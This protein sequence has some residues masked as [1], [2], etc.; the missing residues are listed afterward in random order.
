M[1]I[2]NFFLT[3]YCPLLHQWGLNCFIILLL[4]YTIKNFNRSK[5]LAGTV[6]IYVYMN[7]DWK[8]A[9]MLAIYSIIS[10][11]MIVHLIVA[12]TAPEI[13]FKV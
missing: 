9:H 12:V 11:W 1:I 2:S 10:G 7:W 8:W 13:H 4:C 5:L 6:Y 3:L